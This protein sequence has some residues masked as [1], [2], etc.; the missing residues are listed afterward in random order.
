MSKKNE[1]DPGSKE[2]RTGAG[3]HEEALR[4]KIVTLNVCTRR[5][6]E[7]LLV[8]GVGAD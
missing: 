8:R 1:A 4:A 3:N 6:A 7:M 2:M 5:V